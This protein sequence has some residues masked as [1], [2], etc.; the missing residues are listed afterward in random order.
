MKRGDLPDKWVWPKHP[1]RIFSKSRTG[2]EITLHVFAVFIT[3][4]F[5]LKMVISSNKRD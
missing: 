3:M 2:K 1:I 4:E 5:F